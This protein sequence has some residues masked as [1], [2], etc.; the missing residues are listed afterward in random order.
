MSDLVRQGAVQVLRLP[1]NRATITGPPARV[2]LAVN[3]LGAE[4]R[5]AGATN[6]VPLGDGGVLVTVRLVV[7]DLPAVTAPPPP[8]SW[9]TPA[10]VAIVAVASLAALGTII[11]AVAL[12]LSWLAAHWLVILAIGTVAALLGRGF[13]G[14]AVHVIVSVTVR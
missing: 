9:W 3:T 10:R 4:G 12:A 7:P 11:A 13:L 2:A 8:E 5:L 6:P 14:R 1:G